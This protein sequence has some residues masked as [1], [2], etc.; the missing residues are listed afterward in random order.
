M[1]S[2]RENQ[3]RLAGL[4]VL[5]RTRHADLGADIAGQ[6]QKHCARVFVYR[7]YLRT[8]LLD[9]LLQLEWIALNREIEVAD[10]EAANDVSD[11]ATCQVDVHSSG[12]SYVLDQAD[13]L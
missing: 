1:D 6:G 3:R 9:F 7:R 2:G 12:A 5:L 4:F 10:G 11:R 8:G 13:T